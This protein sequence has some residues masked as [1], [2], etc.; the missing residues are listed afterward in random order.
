MKKRIRR[1]LKLI[2][3]AIWLITKWLLA[4]RK[5]WRKRPRS[6]FTRIT[7]TGILG[8][9]GYLFGRVYI[10]VWHLVVGF[11][12][13]SAALVCLPNGEDQEEEIEEVEGVRPDEDYEIVMTVKFTDLGPKAVFDDPLNPARTHIIDLDRNIDGTEFAA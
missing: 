4:S 7:L 11:A 3:G 8:I 9:V 6:A 2:L 13:L 10:E 5:P 12:V 1:A